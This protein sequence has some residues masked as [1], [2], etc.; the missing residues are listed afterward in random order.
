MTGST[1]DADAP[2]TRAARGAGSW[3]RALL[4]AAVVLLVAALIAWIIHHGR[5][6]QTAAGERRGALGGPVTVEVA[7]AVTGD[8]AVRLAALGTVTPLASVIVKP[9]VSGQLVRLGF[10]EGQEVRKGDFLAEIDP[11]SFEAALRETE[12]NLTRD[13]SMLANARIDLKR[14]QDLAAVEQIARQQLDTQAA[15]VH[16]YEGAVATD[17][18]AV[19]AA[20]VNLQYTHIVA[21]VAGRVGLRQVD[22]GNYVTPG[23]AGGIVVVTQLRPISVVFTLP[24]DELP[25]IQARLRGGASIAVEAW[26]RSNTARLATGT[27]QAIDNQIDTSTGTIR[28]RALFDNSDGALFANQF[29]NVQVVRDVVAHQIVIPG[30]AVQHGAPNGATTTFVYRVNADRTV[31]V[32][33]V[34]LGVADGDRVAVTQGL[35]AGELVVTEG[36]DRLRDGAHVELP[37]PALRPTGTPP[38]ARPGTHKGKGHW[39]DQRG[40]GEADH[41]PA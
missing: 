8:V 18:A 28:M 34:T 39:R 10:R 33:P 14:Y 6:A 7:S 9:Q 29:V 4:G 19:D 38:S 25:A 22:P 30:A 21:P 11:R 12:G 31:S 41:P 23:D 32:Q 1:S 15:L 3:R 17:S 16:Q 26:D 5:Q 24:E 20:R 2:W 27:L 36:G 35:A 40:Q 37:S 13:Q